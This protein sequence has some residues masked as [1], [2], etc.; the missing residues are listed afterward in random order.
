MNF[1]TPYKVFKSCAQLSKTR[2]KLDV[3]LENKVVL[4]LK[5]SKN[6]NNKK[7]GPKM[8]FFNAI[9]FRKIWIIFD[10]EN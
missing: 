6:A 1:F 9:F 10:I 4:K 2:Q 8:I 7:C 5:F 3:I